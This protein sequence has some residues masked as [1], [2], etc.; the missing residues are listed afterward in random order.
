MNDDVKGRYNWIS[1]ELIMKDN[2]LLPTDMA[3]AYL[4]WAF[5]EPSAM[6]GGGGHEG[7]P[8]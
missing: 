7:L 3:R 2:T 1:Q 6:G 4:T 8:S 5:L